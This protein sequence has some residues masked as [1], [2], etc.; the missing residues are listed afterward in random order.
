[1]T[2]RKFLAG[3]YFMWCFQ[4]TEK[5]TWM[6]TAKSQWEQTGCPVHLEIKRKREVRTCLE[7]QEW[8]ITINYNYRVNCWDVL[9]STS[10]PADGNHSQSVQWELP[11]KNHEPQLVKI[12]FKSK[13][14]TPQLHSYSL[15]YILFIL[16]FNRSPGKLEACC[17]WDNCPPMYMLYNSLY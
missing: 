2:W 10:A 16:I 5:T 7:G 1:M 6:E 13:P 9:T 17:F 4:K 11:G 3:Q 15:N 14:F 12:I 8:V